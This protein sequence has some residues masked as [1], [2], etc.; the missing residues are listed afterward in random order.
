MTM[1]TAIARAPSPQSQISMA[2]DPGQEFC[3][4]K[5]QDKEAHAQRQK[6]DIE[7]VEPP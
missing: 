1:Y 5:G 7:H 3:E 6:E 4:G 2:L